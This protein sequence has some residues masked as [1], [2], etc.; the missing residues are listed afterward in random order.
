MSLYWVLSHFLCYRTCLFPFCLNQGFRTSETATSLQG[1]H[2]RDT[3]A[4]ENEWLRNQAL[5]CI[6]AERSVFGWL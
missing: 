2:V 3:S 5:A 1:L 6:A 4:A